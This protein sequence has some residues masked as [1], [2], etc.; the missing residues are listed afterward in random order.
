MISSSM[1]VQHSIPFL[2]F[3]LLV[4]F[5][6]SCKNKTSETQAIRKDL[7]QCVYASGKL[8]PV[9]DYKVFSKF[10]GY[11]SEI[12]V[13]VGDTVASGAALITVRNDQTE[14]SAE[15]A[16]NA[17]V[18][19]QKNN[20]PNSPLL[21]ALKN[22]VSTAKAR[23]DLDSLNF[24]RYS[25]LVKQ[26]A[27]AQAQF[28]Q[29]KLQF[30]ISKQNL[31]KAQNN[32]QTTKDRLATEAANAE[33][34]Y[35]TLLANK[36]EYLITADKKGMVYDIDAKKGE[37]ISVQKPIMEIGDKYKFELELFI[38]ETDIRFVKPGQ[39]VIFTIDAFDGQTFNAKVRE[40]YPRISQT[41]KT[42]KVI[43]E[44]ENKNSAA[45][46]SSLSVEAN[47]II[48]TKKNALVIPREFLIGKNQVKVKGEENLKIVT[49]GIENIDYVEILSGI[50][51]NAT[52]IKP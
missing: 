26:N 19:A 6:F 51:E 15:S 43:A 49:T 18:L 17:M 31:L 29:T 36:N 41:N 47:I 27:V 39:D 35:K 14:F 13:H 7:T 28:E 21:A 20:T 16:K 48:S 42:I 12:H 40:I 3:S 38:D 50:D 32:F 2:V 24:A 1:R 52:L 25:N 30:D 4:L 44:I 5:A 37:M 45:F 23:F 10:P 34:Q 22:E 8:F 46:Y 33:L 11:I 9:D